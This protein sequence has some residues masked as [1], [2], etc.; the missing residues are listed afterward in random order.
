MASFKN[1][2]FFRDLVD[3]IS[4][5]RQGGARIIIDAEDAATGSG[6]TSAAVALAECISRFYGYDLTP[7]DGVL[8]AQRYFE[9]WTNHPGKEQPSVIILDEL[10]GGGAADGRRAMSSKNVGLARAWETMRT[11][12]IVTITTLPHWSYA[13]SKMRQLADYRLH[14]SRDPIGQ[15]QA[16]RIGASFDDGSTKTRTLGKSVKFPDMASRGHELYDSLSDKKDKLLEAQMM[17]ADKAL[18]DGSSDQRDPDDIERDQKITMAQRARNRGM[19]TTEIAELVGMSQSWVSM[20][21]DG[22]AAD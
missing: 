2:K 9:R 5:T 6:K 13:D 16:Y 18:T 17:D 1:S 7:I 10:S 21:T 15:F 14:C 12:R 11:K 22:D 8:S 3:G 4:G 19:P 20:N